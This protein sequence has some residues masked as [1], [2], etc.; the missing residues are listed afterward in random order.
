MYREDNTMSSFR[1]YMLTES[2]NIAAACADAFAESFRNVSGLIF[3]RDGFKPLSADEIIRGI[4]TEGIDR[5]RIFDSVHDG[6]AVA[7][8]VSSGKGGALEEK[9]PRDRLFDSLSRLGYDAKR[10]FELSVMPGIETIGRFLKDMGQ[11]FSEAGRNAG[12]RMKRNVACLALGMLMFAPAAGR[13]LSRDVLASAI[14]AGTAAIGREESAFHLR[15]T[16][17]SI[18]GVSSAEALDLGDILGGILSGMSGARSTSRRVE[19]QLRR[20]GNMDSDA[21]YILAGILF[22]VLSTGDRSKNSSSNERNTERESKEEKIRDELADREKVRFQKMVDRL[23]AKGD[24][25]TLRMFLVV[26]E[27]DSFDR[28]DK[29]QTAVD[30]GV[31]LENVVYRMHADRDVLHFFKLFSGVVEERKKTAIVQ[32]FEYM[33]MEDIELGNRDDLFR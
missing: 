8:A 15:E 21:G 27:G 22:D 20:I 11:S 13:V 5:N 7:V 30:G 25:D 17:M 9:A 2:K 12:S 10:V 29:F 18:L 16:A 1:E 24:K 19:N 6:A 26:M 3:D 23:D 4:D 14:G 32:V 33:G 31:N 28:A